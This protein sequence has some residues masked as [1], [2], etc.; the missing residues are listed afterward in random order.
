MSGPGS[1]KDD[2]LRR[3]TSSNALTD[4]LLSMRFQPPLH[5]RGSL[6]VR[7]PRRTPHEQREFLA[8]M[9]REALA[10]VDDD[11]DFNDDDDSADDDDKKVGSSNSS[12]SH[13]DRKQ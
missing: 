6:T 10:V 8:S 2:S 7:S 11:C 1:S 3:R 12:T 9:L 13:G 4:N 5:P